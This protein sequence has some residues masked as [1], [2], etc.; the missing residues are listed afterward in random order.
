MFFGVLFNCWLFD[1][2][3]IDTPSNREA[4]KDA[5]FSQWTHPDAF[6]DAI[7]EWTT[8]M[9]NDIQNGD[10]YEFSTTNGNTE[11]NLVTIEAKL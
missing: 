9:Y 8:S 6:S 5:D 7:Y 3:T 1:R 2:V 10:M 4:M 11:V